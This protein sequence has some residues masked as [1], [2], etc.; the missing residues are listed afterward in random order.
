MRSWVPESELSVR[1]VGGAV[2]GPEGSPCQRR[3]NCAAGQL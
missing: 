3:H 1:G 2:A